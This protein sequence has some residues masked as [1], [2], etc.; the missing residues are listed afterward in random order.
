MD[1]ERLHQIR[2]EHALINNLK[3]KIV[4]ESEEKGTEKLR[5]QHEH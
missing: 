1:E 3:K 2:E 4:R 5:Q